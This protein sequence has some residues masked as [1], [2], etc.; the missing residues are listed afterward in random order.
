[1]LDEQQLGWG[2]RAD[3]AWLSTRDFGCDPNAH[4]TDPRDGSESPNNRSR[5]LFRRT[6]FVTLSVVAIIE[7]LIR[8]PKSL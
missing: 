8:P 3:G 7:G 1:M 6:W 4:S 2:G 5:G